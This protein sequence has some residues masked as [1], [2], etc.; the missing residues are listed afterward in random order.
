VFNIA[1]IHCSS[2]Q[3]AGIHAANVTLPLQQLRDA[4]LTLRHPE[5]QTCLLMGENGE[6]QIYPLIGENDVQVTVV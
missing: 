5:L 2:T 1:L 6:T 4:R 3:E